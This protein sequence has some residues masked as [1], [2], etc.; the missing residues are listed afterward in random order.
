MLGD[1]A[2]PASAIDAVQALTRS[3]DAAALCALIEALYASRAE[4]G[5]A[6]FDALLG[7]VRDTLRASIDRRMEYAE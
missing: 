5:D 1:G 3:R 6:R 2:T 7:R 4:L